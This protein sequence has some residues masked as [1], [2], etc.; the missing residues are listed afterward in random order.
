GLERP[1]LPLHGLCALLRSRKRPRTHHPGTG[2]GR[3]LMKHAQ[4]TATVLRC[5]LTALGAALLCVGGGN[6]A[7]AASGPAATAVTV[8]S[9][10]NGDSDQLVR[11][12]Y[13]AHAAD[14][15]A[16]HT[17]ENGAPFA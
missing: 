2:K 9:T 14:C 11:G 6:A 8:Q 12:R 1:Y 15:A 17:A 4:T 10:P 7:S 16:C 13:L 3:D 5:A